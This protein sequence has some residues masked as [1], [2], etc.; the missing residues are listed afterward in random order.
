MLLYYAY[1]TTG[2]SVSTSTCRLRWVELEQDRCN[3]R[4]RVRRTR[5]ILGVLNEKVQVED[6]DVE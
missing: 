2:S 4:F 5:G 3:L 1:A 6:A